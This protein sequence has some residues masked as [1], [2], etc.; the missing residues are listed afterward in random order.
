MLTKKKIDIVI[1]VF[2]EGSIIVDTLQSIKDNFFCE[3]NILICYDFNTDNTL[4]AIKK[5]NLNFQNIFFI[6]NNYTG[7]HGAVMSGIEK[8]V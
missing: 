6:K 5:S 3:Y 8:S 7:S 1:P 2:N 4:P